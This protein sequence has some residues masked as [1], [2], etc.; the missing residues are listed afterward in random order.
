MTIAS[1]RRPE[2]RLLHLNEIDGEAQ[3]K[4][5]FLRQNIGR[6]S[7]VVVIEVDKPVADQT[8]SEYSCQHR[9]QEKQTCQVSRRG[10]MGTRGVIFTSD[11]LSHFVR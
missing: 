9:E 8:L 1:S 3:L 6:L 5:A 4:Q 11:R 7:V 10:D 2:N